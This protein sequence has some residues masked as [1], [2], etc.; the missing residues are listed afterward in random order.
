MAATP[1]QVTPARATPITSNRS[2]PPAAL[3]GPL[4]R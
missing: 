1:R 4:A 2:P 3:C